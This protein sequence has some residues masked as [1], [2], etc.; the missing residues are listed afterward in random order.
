MLQLFFNSPGT[1]HMEFIS[2]GA[3]V[4]K[5]CYK[6]ILRHLCNSICHKCSVLWHRKN[7]LLLHNNA[8]ARGS[9]LV[10]EDLEKQEIAF[11]HTLHIHLILLRAISFSFPAYK[12][13]YVGSHMGPSCKY[14]SAVF[15]AVI[16]TL[17]DSQSGQQRL[18]ERRMWICVSVWV[19]LV[20]WCDKTTVHEII[21]CNSIN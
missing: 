4:N 2:E 5:H 14:H 7:W 1:V 12:K 21:D 16:P 8:P 20:I 13:S 10:Q 17:A 15:P 18:F 9:M 3:T 11:C 19:Y 6:K